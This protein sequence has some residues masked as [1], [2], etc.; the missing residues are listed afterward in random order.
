MQ[1]EKDKGCLYIHPAAVDQKKEINTE[2]DEPSQSDSEE[3]D[4]DARVIMPSKFNLKKNDLT[5]KS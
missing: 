3:T 2:K 5:N 1:N 4:H